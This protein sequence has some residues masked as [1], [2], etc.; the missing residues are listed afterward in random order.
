[1][2]AAQALY[3]SFDFVRAARFEGSETANTV[4][5]PLTI[6]MELDLAKASP[7]IRSTRSG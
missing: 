7:L 6:A 5:D 2:S 3:R 1:M 4:L